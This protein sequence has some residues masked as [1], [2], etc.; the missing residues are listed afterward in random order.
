MMH[1]ELYIIKNGERLRIDLKTP[2]GITLN[3][4][5]N[6]FGDL[7]KISA[8]HTYTFKLPMTLNNRNVLESPEDIRRYSTASRR[9]FKCEF[10]QN[11]IDLFNDANLYVDTTD[12]DSY[13]AVM[14]WGIVAGFEALKDGDLSLRDLGAGINEMGRYG[15]YW[16]PTPQ[17]FDNGTLLLHPYRG[18]EIYEESGGKIWCMVNVDGKPVSKAT[19]PVVPIRYIIERI[20]SVF[21]TKF[22]LGSRYDGDT[23]WDATSHYYKSN[24]D[25]IIISRGVVPLVS[26][27]LTDEQFEARTATL[28]NFKIFDYSIKLWGSFTVPLDAWDGLK[29]PQIVTFDIKQPQNNVYFTVGGGGNV[30]PSVKWLF[31]KKDSTGS[32]IVMVEKFKLDGYFKVVFMGTSTTVPKMILYHR[33]AERDPEDSTKVNI[34]MKEMETLEG[35]FDGYEYYADSDLGNRLCDVYIFDFRKSQGLSPIEI[36]ETGENATSSSSQYPYFFNF[37]RKAYKISEGSVEI[38]P[39]GK[40]SDDVISKG[41]ETDIF[42]NLPDV[43][44]LEFMKS[45]FY[46]IGAFPGLSKDGEI[47]PLRYGAISQNMWK[48]NVLDWSKK[49][50]TS[51][52]DNPEKIDFKISG[53]GQHNFFLLKNDDLDVTEP[54]EGEDVYETGK[55]DIRCDNNSL[56]REKTIIQIPWFGPY[57]KSGKYPP[58]RTNRDMKY[59]EFDTNEWRYKG[60]EAKPAIG[61]IMGCPEGKYSAEYDSAGNVTKRIYTPNGTYRM[62]MEILNPFRDATE[63]S[64]Y[65]F[66]QEVIYRP[67]V[68]TENFILDEFDLKDIDYTVPIYL[69]KYNS[70][71]AIVSIQRDS[72]GKCKCELIKLP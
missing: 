54:E 27:G 64:D 4:K 12:K 46:V 70:H 50:M 33:V 44:C 7:S 31:Y 62:F 57:L 24:G 26:V 49:I 63:S 8:S 47:I 38:T 45:L 3:F 68:I 39:I 61:L 34:S 71:F 29:M 56:E 51:V 67:Y 20:N 36:E 2:S 17:T 40:L 1:E 22:N 53:F 72:N 60:C 18:L 43:G 5:S 6:L 52:E 41:F 30:D 65:D 55:M 28:T 9:K 10:W 59:E 58:A 13:N 23:Y 35:R 11:G 48:G 69:D 16:T 32:K 37:D 19:I 21:G 15:N 42:S 14:T 25:S 66:L